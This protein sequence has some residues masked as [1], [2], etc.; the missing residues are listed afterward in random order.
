[1]MFPPAVPDSE[2]PGMDLILAFAASMLLEWQAR[3]SECGT[4]FFGTSQLHL[5]IFCC[6]SSIICTLL[7]TVMKLYLRIYSQR[8]S[9]A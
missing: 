2:V 1:M 6:V 4:M 3:L 7:N 5:P 9:G 8:Y